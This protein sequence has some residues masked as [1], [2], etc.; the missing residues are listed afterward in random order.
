VPERMAPDGWMNDGR[1]LTHE[2]QVRDFSA[3][4][5]L[6][7][8]IAQAANSLNHHPDLRVEYGRVVASIT[9]H[10]AGRSLTNKDFD[11]AERLA[12]L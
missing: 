6:A 11:L 12:S 8:A 7:A 9:T 5:V 3:A 4:V 10:E 2:W 1:T